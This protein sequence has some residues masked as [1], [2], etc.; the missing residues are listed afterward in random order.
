MIYTVTYGVTLCASSWNCNYISCWWN[1]LQMSC[2]V[3]MIHHSHSQLLFTTAFKYISE[4][5]INHSLNIRT[6]RYQKILEGRLLKLLERMRG[7]VHNNWKNFFNF[8]V[9]SLTSQIS[10]FSGKMKKKMTTKSGNPAVKKIPP[11]YLVLLSLA[12]HTPEHDY[13]VND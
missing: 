13:K 5:I 4:R 7:D 2:S 6:C 3:L 9:H 12:L 11:F 1:L 8:F 10:F